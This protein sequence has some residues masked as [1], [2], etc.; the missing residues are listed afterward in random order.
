MKDWS[1]EQW[2]TQKGFLWNQVAPVFAP[3]FVLDGIYVI[4]KIF[5][6]YDH[7]HNGGKFM[8][9]IARYHRFFRPHK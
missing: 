2:F 9:W 7:Y 5:P 6:R 1:P 4:E 3:V 8:G